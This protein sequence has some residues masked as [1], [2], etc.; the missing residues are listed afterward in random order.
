LAPGI[1]SISQQFPNHY[2]V[3]AVITN[4][5]QQLQKTCRIRSQLP[6][7]PLASLGTKDFSTFRLPLVRVVIRRKCLGVILAGSFQSLAGCLV[8]VDW[9]PIPEN[10]YRFANR[11]GQPS[12]IPQKRTVFAGKKIPGEGGRE[13]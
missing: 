10:R 8:R 2:A 12:P 4:G 1:P 7:P 3:L 11:Q 5:V 6:P 13:R 9:L